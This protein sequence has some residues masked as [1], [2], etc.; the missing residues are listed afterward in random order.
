MPPLPLPVPQHNLSTSDQPFPSFSWILPTH[1][2]ALIKGE[3]DAATKKY[4]AIMAKEGKKF[5][6]FLEKNDMT[7]PA[8]E[9]KED[10]LSDK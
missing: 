7:K 6:S 5:M 8:V 3:F 1:N 10:F 9:S 2:F 4:N